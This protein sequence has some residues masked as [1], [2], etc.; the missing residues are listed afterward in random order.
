MR[1]L[2]A[3]AKVDFGPRLDAAVALVRSKCPDAAVVS[4][5]ELPWEQILASEAGSWDRAYAWAQRNHDTLVVVET[6][7][8]ALG[9]G[10]FDLCQRFLQAEKVVGVVRGDRVAPVIGCY[11]SAIQS[12][13]DCY[14]LVETPGDADA[15]EERALLE[16]F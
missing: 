14:G 13:K 1:I 12:W 3:A 15:E 8:K 10:T 4:S 16:T 2:V 5:S 11:K 9:R 7:K 6:G